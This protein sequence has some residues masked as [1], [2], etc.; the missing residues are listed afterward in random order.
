MFLKGFLVWGRDA[1]PCLLPAQL[2]QHRHFNEGKTSRRCRVGLCCNLGPVINYNWP[3]IGTQ[4]DQRKLTALKVLLI[5]DVLIGRNH[6][7]ETRSFCI[8][9]K[10]PVFKLYGPSRFDKG[11]D[12]MVR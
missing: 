5:A 12:L 3:D 2:W 10:V 1:L 4:N 11:A 9:Q 6:H 8:F 7:V